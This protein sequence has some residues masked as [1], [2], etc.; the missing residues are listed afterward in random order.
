MPK[1]KADNRNSSIAESYFY[2]SRGICYLA[3]FFLTVPSAIFEISYPMWRSIS[4]LHDK[5]HCPKKYG[6]EILVN[7]N[8]GWS[9]TITPRTLTTC[10]LRRPLQ[11]SNSTL[12]SFSHAPLPQLIWF[13]HENDLMCLYSCLI[14]FF[15]FIRNNINDFFVHYIPAYMIDVFAS[16]TGRKPM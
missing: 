16:L 4:D 3:K 7:G 10:W 13:L 5:R 11:R 8:R 12:T 1:R 14:W 6:V 9:P 2:P 15:W